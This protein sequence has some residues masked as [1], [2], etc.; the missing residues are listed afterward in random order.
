MALEPPAATAVPEPPG[1]RGR[2]RIRPAVVITALVALAVLSVVAL[3]LLLPG[4]LDRGDGAD[5]SSGAASGAPDTDR[6]TSIPGTDERR[7]AG[8]PVPQEPVDA[9]DH[10][11]VVE[12]ATVFVL[13]PWGGPSPDPALVEGTASV[14]RARIGSA[15]QVEV[16]GSTLTVVFADPPAG[17]VV[18]LLTGPAG[19]QL[20]RV[21]NYDAGSADLPDPPRAPDAEYA[22]AWNE[23]TGQGTPDWL[24]DIGLRFAVRE[25]DDR[26]PRP[27]TPVD[28]PMVAC[29]LD[30]SLR[31]LLAPAEV[32]APDVAAARVLDDLS[33]W[34]VEVELDAA[35]SEALARLTGSL[36][37]LTMPFNQ[38]AV[39]S[40]GHV[41]SAAVVQ[42]QIAG[43]VMIL[44]VPQ[45][46][47][48][49]DIAARLLL[50]GA[51]L[52]WRV[53]A[54]QAH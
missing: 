27:A 20:R 16:S 6:K 35:G 52:Q 41:V 28:E 29:A 2:R 33:G 44:T 14:L 54:T 5:V 30:G 22:R 25:C 19:V 38:L 34:H 40:D 21:M 46:A 3:V 24:Q 53:A 1:S 4:L 13:E 9:P 47:E 8:D 26:S 32:G 31:Y 15:G 36:S 39:V 45:Q 50:G 43:G 51:D 49:L 11:P 18:D 17:D 10:A 37:R 23:L 12:G 42:E 48:A 7:S